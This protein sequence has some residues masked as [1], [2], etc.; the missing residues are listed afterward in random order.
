MEST[1]QF[2][3][4][5]GYVVLFVWVVLE[6]GGLP[7]PAKVQA[8]VGA[9]WGHVRGFALP[10]GTSGQN[11]SVLEAARRISVQRRACRG[12]VLAPKILAVLRLVIS[13]TP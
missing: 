13:S 1:I 4:R 12:A 6:Q 11:E 5:H 8:F 2:L 3:I 10:A 7:I 9:Q